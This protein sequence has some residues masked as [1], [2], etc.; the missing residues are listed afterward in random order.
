[1]GRQNELQFA[2]I[3]ELLADQG[4]QAFCSVLQRWKR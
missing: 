2:R 4:C 3:K 1:M